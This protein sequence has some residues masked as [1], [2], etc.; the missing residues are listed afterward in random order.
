M[1]C[2]KCGKELI[3][4]A[5]FCDNCGCS[6]DNSTIIN[7]DYRQAGASVQPIK[8]QYQMK[9]IIQI[10]KKDYFASVCSPKAKKLKT[11]SWI[12]WG[13][14]ILLCI[15]VLV[16]A[17][18]GN[19]LSS[20]TGAVYFDGQEVQAGTVE[21]Y[22][23]KE[24]FEMLQEDS[25]LFY[26]IIVGL[27]LMAVSVIVTFLLGLL[28]CNTKSVGLSV[29]FLIAAILSLSPGKIFDLAASIC[30]LI[31]NVKLNRE[32][33]QYICGNVIKNN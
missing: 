13:I 32:Y 24:T 7:N 1:F 19:F 30:V 9:P 31:F 4:N 11:A 6:I 20:N 29:A 15:A 26:M 23:I 10:S 5:K 28:S 27:A 21:N 12:V 25:P 2:Q 14:S 17:F 8:Y 18:S 33:K 3:E 16:L 22:G